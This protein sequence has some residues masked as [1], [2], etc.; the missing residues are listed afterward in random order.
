MR[1]ENLRRKREIYKEKESLPQSNQSNSVFSFFQKT[2]RMSDDE[3]QNLGLAVNGLAES[4]LV[5]LPR[6]VASENNLSNQGTHDHSTSPT[7]A[8]L[9]HPPASHGKLSRKTPP[10]HTQSPYGRGKGSNDY[11]VLQR[12][13]H[14]CGAPAPAAS[15]NNSHTRVW[16]P[17]LDLQ[18]R[19]SATGT[20]APAA[21]LEIFVKGEKIYDAFRNAKVTQNTIAG[22]DSEM[23][24]LHGRI[25]EI[26]SEQVRLNQQE[27]EQ[28]REL[29]ALL[30]PQHKKGA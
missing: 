26:R 14:T 6:T 27:K 8:L 17:R 22:L 3:R 25:R 2:T 13:A 21:T 12:Q 1:E 16:T 20:S 19:L 15:N 5:G 4:T 7:R 24:K 29:E 18:S 11:P 23:E 28:V 10:F 30:E 9:P